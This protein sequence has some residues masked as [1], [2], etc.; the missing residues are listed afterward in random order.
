[1]ILETLLYPVI[2]LQEQLL[3]FFFHLSGNAGLSLIFSAITWVIVLIPFE[4]WATSAALKEREIKNVLK[5]QMQKIK[6]EAS[7]KREKKIKALY[8]R[9]SYHPIYSMRL[10]AGFL[11]QLP[12]LIAVYIIFSDCNIMENQSFFFITNLNKPDNLLSGINLLPFVITG[13][14][15]LNVFVINR[16]AV[17]E[18]IS[19]ILLSIA[20]FL[21][22]YDHS[23]AM[24]SFWTVYQTIS[25]TNNALKYF[26]NKNK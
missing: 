20:V 9:Y 13:L 5:V 4:K 24:L 22:L 21:L 16:W 7:C 3:S 8:R 25:L 11:I 17:K 12:L 10:S 14:S 23:A 19:G 18:S 2:Y 1:M 26:H 6:E 15:F